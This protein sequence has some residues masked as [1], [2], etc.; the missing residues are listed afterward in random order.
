MKDAATLFQSKGAR[1]I[2]ASQTAANPYAEGPTWKN[3]SVPEFVAWSEQVAKAVGADFID[4]YHLMLAKWKTMESQEVNKDF[5]GP[6]HTNPDGAQIQAQVFA[7]SL[8]SAINSP[9]K[10]QRK[11]ARPS[12][13]KRHKAIV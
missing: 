2:I 10:Q 7:Q 13:G 4:H 8:V 12:R 1:V 3:L 11:K 9:S 6:I 5:I